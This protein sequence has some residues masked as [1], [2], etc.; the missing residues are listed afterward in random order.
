MKFL[1]KILLFLMLGYTAYGQKKNAGFRYPMNQIHTPIKVDGVPDDD[2]W[3]SIH[4]ASDFYMVLPMDTSHAKGRTDVRMCYD[5]KNMYLLVEAYHMIDKKIKVE[6][7]K[8]DFSFVKNDNFLLF[9]DPYDDRTNGFSFG[10]NAA[11]ALWDG[12]MYDGGKVD[13]SWENK[14]RGVTKNFDDK[15]VFEASIPFKSIRYKKGITEWG[16]NFSRLDIRTTEKSSWTPIP[17]IFP[18]AAL[19]Y[20]GTLVWDQPPPQAGTNI[21]YN[22]VCSFRCFKKFPGE[23][24]SKI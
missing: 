13:L 24:E 22:T 1:L 8:R 14:W 18:T 9:M 11:G 10:C 5:Q 23:Y 19:A 7:L 21:L 12:T 6:S 4:I 20:T 3:K 15:W 2:T 17:R 16:I